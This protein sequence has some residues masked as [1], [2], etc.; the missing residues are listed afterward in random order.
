MSSAKLLTICFS[1]LPFPVIGY[2]DEVNGREP[3]DI[4]Y[5]DH[6]HHGYSPEQGHI[7]VM[8]DASVLAVEDRGN[9]SMVKAFLFINGRMSRRQVVE[10]MASMMR[11]PGASEQFIAS[12]EPSLMRKDSMQKS[13]FTV[14][15]SENDNVLHR[16]ILDEVMG[17]QFYVLN[18]ERMRIASRL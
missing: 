3:S 4:F 6:L 7:F 9:Q 18:Y 15:L 11:A 5:S 10:R 13:R 8:P 1:L 12:V 14:E 17:R 16:F 2:C